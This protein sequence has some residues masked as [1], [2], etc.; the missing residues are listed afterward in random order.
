MT[1]Y[2][3]PNDHVT[4]GDAAHGALM[5]LDDGRQ[6]RLRWLHRDHTRAVVVIGGRHH[7]IDPARIARV[8]RQEKPDMTLN[9]TSGTT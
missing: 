7:R 9:V 8:I 1:A 3:G 6:G 5:V 2:V 4:L